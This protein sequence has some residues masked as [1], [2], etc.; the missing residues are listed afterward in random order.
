MLYLLSWVYSCEWSLV[1]APRQ[2]M[3]VERVAV[4]VLGD[5]GSGPMDLRPVLGLP[6]FLGAQMPVPVLVGEA[7]QA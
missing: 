6:G 5:H 4:L 7:R 2:T 1:I 3:L